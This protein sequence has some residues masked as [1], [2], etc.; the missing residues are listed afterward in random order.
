MNFIN[1]LANAFLLYSVFIDSPDIQTIA[2]VTQSL[3]IT[4]LVLSTSNPIIPLTQTC[5]KSFIAYYGQPDYMRWLALVWGTSDLIRYLYHVTPSIGMIK[6]ARYSQYKLLYPI[7]ISLELM[8]LLPVLSYNSKIIVSALYIV[9]FPIMFNHTSKL[10]SKVYLIEL[11]ERISSNREKDIVSVEF[12]KR[13]YTVSH[14][15]LVYNLS[16]TRYK[17][18][19]VNNVYLLKDPGLL[20]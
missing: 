16:N 20:Y 1:M 9:I 15:L 11:L 17:L 3:Q 13:T 7:G 10:E 6:R 8:T 14:K 18:K 2:F 4:D 19:V 12:N 5:A